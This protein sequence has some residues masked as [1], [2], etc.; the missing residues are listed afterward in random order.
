MTYSSSRSTL[1]RRPRGRRPV[2]VPRRRR[3]GAVGEAGVRAVATQA[4]ANVTYGPDALHAVAAG[5]SASEVLER[6]VAA[7]ALREQRQLGIV[8][9][10]AARRP[11]GGSASRGRV[12]DRARVHGAGQHPGWRGGRRRAGGHLPRGRPLVPRGSSSPASPPRTRPAAIDAGASRRRSSWSAPVAVRRR[13]RSLGRPPCR[14]PRRPDR[15]GSRASSTS[16]AVP[17][18]AGRLRPR[19]TR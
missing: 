17:G 10:P 16:T 8:A 13:Q 4:F 14:R 5:R 6:L 19:T 3:G 1:D 18:P 12:P 7:D 15:R 9:A 11:T 2:E